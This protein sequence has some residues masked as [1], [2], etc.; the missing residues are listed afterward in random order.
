[1]GLRM[2]KETSITVAITA[3]AE[4]LLLV[5][6]MN[7][8]QRAMSRLRP[9][10]EVEVLLCLDRSN[11]ETKEVAGSYSHWAKI[12]QVDFGDPGFSRNHLTKNATGEFV[13]ILDGDDLFC[14]NWLERALNQAITDRRNIVWHPEVNVVFGELEYVFY[15]TDMESADYNAISPIFCNPWTSL[16]FAKRDLFLGIPY[17][18]CDFRAGVGHED[19]TWNRRVIEAGWLHKVVEGT[20]HGIRRKPTSQVKAAS[21]ARALPLPTTIGTA[22]LLERKLLADR[23]GALSPGLGL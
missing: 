23:K 6:T 11:Q 20:G 5:P 14:S 13:A 15:H 12:H 19:W 17:P 21:A 16:C 22:I 18:G 8:V 3:H 10:V 2:N 9:S 1:M 7:S 4:G